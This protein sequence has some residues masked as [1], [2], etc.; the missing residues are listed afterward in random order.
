MRRGFKRTM[1]FGASA[2]NA[3]AAGFWLGGGREAS[4]NRSEFMGG[5]LHDAFAGGIAFDGRGAGHGPFGGGLGCMGTFSAATGLV[6]CTDTRGGVVVTR[7]AK[8]TTATGTVQRGFDTLTTNTVVLTSQAAGTITYDRASDSVAGVGRDH[9]W[10]RGRGHGGRLLGETSTILTA[11]TTVNSTS[12]RTASGLAS[13]S[14]QRNVS[15]ASA[16]RES[17]TG[18]STRGSFTASRTVGDTSTALVIPVVTGA[19]SY[20]TAGTVIRSIS[21]SL[22]YGTT[23]PVTLSR[24][25]VIAYDGSAVAKV[26]ITENGVTKSC[27]RQ[28]PRGP[29]TCS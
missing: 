3:D 27:T 25:E 1:M 12:S 18:T 9:H 24:R 14:T 19:H 13:G 8:Y 29:L 22:Q 7:S 2:A 23:A 16:G 20:P 26:V 5:G 15:G 21:A 6:T 11:V 28:L 17:T 4:F 10:H